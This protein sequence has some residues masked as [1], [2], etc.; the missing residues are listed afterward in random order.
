MKSSSSL[1][2][3]VFDDGSGESAIYR[4]SGAMIG[5]NAPV[6]RRQGDEVDGV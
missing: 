5:S 1:M 2:V 4:E 3:A 6:M